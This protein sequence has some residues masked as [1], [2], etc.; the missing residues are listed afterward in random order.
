MA[1]R[2]GQGAGAEYSEERK[3]RISAA[4]TG[5]KQSAEHFKARTATRRAHYEAGDQV[6][7][8]GE[9]GTVV[10]Y[11]GIFKGLTVTGA[12][13]KTY[14]VRFDHKVRMLVHDVLTRV[15]A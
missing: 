6:D 8:F 11:L 14:K 13:Q 4:K 3:R 7:W 15:A 1:A 12:K 2:K 5:V 10:E 9:L